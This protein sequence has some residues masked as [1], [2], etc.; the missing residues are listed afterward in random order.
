MPCTSLINSERHIVSLY[1][2]ILARKWLLA[3]MRDII[4][5]GI[6][7]QNSNSGWFSLDF[8]VA[9]VCV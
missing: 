4:I 5:M 8:K 9:G 6:Q 1:H 2:C 7:T 3:V